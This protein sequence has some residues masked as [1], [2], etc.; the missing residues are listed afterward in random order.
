[1]TQKLSKGHIGWIDSMSGK[2]QLEYFIHKNGEL[3][4]APDYGYIDIDGYRSGARWEAPAHMI[5][6]K[7]ALVGLS[8]PIIVDDN[9]YGHADGADPV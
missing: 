4:R 7:L 2:Y 3:Y 8:H 9:V 6:E 1:M 5:D